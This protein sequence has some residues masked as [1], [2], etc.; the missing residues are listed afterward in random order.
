[1]IMPDL[2]LL[3]LESYTVTCAVKSTVE[4][5]FFLKFETTQMKTVLHARISPFFRM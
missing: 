1:M 4:K 5:F 3:N 2:L